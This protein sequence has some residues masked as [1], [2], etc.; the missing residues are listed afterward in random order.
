VGKRRLSDE[1]RARWA[2][3]ADCP[4]AWASDVRLNITM[5]G[6]TKEASLEHA[7][8]TAVQGKPGV[9][10]FDLDGTL[11][12]GQTTLLL[13][14]FLRKAGVVSR[15]FLVGTALW[16]VGYKL[17]LLKV[18]ERSRHQGA[19]VFAG[20]SVADIDELMRRFTDEVLVPRFHAASTAALVEH[21]SVSDHVVVIS[22]ALEP[23]V[24]AV[25]GHLGVRE[26]VGTACEVQDGRYC[27]RLVGPSPHGEVKGVVAAVYM[28]RWGVDAAD[29]WAYADHGSDLALMRSVGHPVAVSP[30]PE[31][32]AFARDAGW[33]VM[34]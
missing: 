13:V 23:V 33:P 1:N 12:V 18:T 5:N 21:Q 3:L 4:V 27:G 25:C 34:T 32:L 9:A 22:A 29:C 28:K 6:T 26:F 11:V 16:F 30:K 7:A 2:S 31:L 8:A 14:R 20:R 19:R 10:F 17:G 15:G 24:K